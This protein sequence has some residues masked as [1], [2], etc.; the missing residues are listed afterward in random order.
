[1]MNEVDG[2]KPVDYSKDWVMQSESG[3]G[4]WKRKSLP[5][6]S[7]I[8]VKELH[9]MLNRNDDDQWMTRDYVI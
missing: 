2:M 5:F 4:L 8:A 6:T 1:M 3:L 9:C 7:L